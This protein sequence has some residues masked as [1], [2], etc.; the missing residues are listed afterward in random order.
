MLEKFQELSTD[1]KIVAILII[2]FTSLFLIYILIRFLSPTEQPADSSFE[3]SDNVVPPD[4]TTI[5]ESVPDEPAEEIDTTLWGGSI[6]DDGLCYDFEGNLVDMSWCSDSYPNP[7]L[8]DESGFNY[9]HNENFSETATV[10]LN[11]ACNKDKSETVQD[12]I[13]RVSLGEKIM[14]EHSQYRNLIFRKGISASCQPLSLQIIEESETS[15]IIDYSMNVF[16]DFV[17]SDD[18]LTTTIKYNIVVEK[19]SDG[20]YAVSSAS[21]TGWERYMTEE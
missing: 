5:V 2:S 16:L 3:I 11:K 1:K 21:T 12:V 14:T 7:D 13:S 18:F 19:L 15:A 10:F 8:H 9:E 6:G 17:F 20:S 4:T